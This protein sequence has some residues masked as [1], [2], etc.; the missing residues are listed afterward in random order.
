MF[1][2]N[3]GYDLVVGDVFE[4]LVTCINE[5]GSYVDCGEMSWNSSNVTVGTMDGANITCL[6]VGSTNI[7]VTGFNL[8]DE[9]I[10]V[11]IA[12][13]SGINNVTMSSDDY[14]VPECGS[15]VVEVRMNSSNGVEEWMAVIE[16]DPNVVN[17]TGVNFSDTVSNMLGMWSHN[18]SYIVA[19]GMSSYMDP[20]SGDWRLVNITVEGNGTG[21][22]DLEFNESE[23]FLAEGEIPVFHNVTW[24]GGSIQCV[25]C[26]D[27]DCD[28]R[29]TI[30]DV[31]ETY[32]KVINPSHV[33]GFD[34]AADV[35]NDNR[36]TINDVVE[37]Y[38]KV[39]NPSH[40]L[41]CACS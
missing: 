2:R 8:T 10:Q 27:V 37:I 36:I 34:W 30:N 3:G 31:V 15:T 23:C 14:Y 1:I 13:P 18:G 20:V 12:A 35:D 4:Y 41:N 29:V 22:T 33:I 40:T 9:I 6:A 24:E 25:G 28:N 32:F 11:V 17:I 38:F 39:I 19:W 16:F 5:S 26:G 21:V 7:N